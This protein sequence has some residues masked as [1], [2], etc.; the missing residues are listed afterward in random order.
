MKRDKDGAQLGRDAEGC[1]KGKGAVCTIARSIWMD[2]G[3]C[4]GCTGKRQ[5]STGCERGRCIHFYSY[6]HT[7]TCRRG[8]EKTLGDE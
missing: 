5:S 8:T 4:G 6:L 1:T 3:V 7:H 2:G